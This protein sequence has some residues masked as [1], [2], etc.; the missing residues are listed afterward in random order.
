M[1]ICDELEVWSRN[2]MESGRRNGVRPR[3]GG[4]LAPALRLHFLPGHVGAAF[5]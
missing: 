2:R 5:A 3:R 1:A 4:S